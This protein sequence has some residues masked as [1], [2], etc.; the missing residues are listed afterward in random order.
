MA[1]APKTSAV[2]SVAGL[3]ASIGAPQAG[4]LTEA[5][6]LYSKVLARRRDHFDALPM[7]SVIKL[8]KGDPEEALRLISEAMRLAPPGCLIYLYECR[9]RL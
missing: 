5:E 4:R 2:Q 8:A 7:L 9:V 6:Q 3:R 1:P